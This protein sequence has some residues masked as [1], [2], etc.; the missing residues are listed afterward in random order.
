M[1]KIFLLIAILI[2]MF[3]SFSFFKKNKGKKPTSKGVFVNM[4]KV[5]IAMIIAFKDF[6]DEEC[7]V[8]KRIF[9]KARVEVKVVS[10]Q[11][12][13]ARGAHGGEIQ[14]DIQL[15][16][17]KVADFDGILFVGGPGA[18][19]HLDNED[20]YKIAKNS[21]AQNKLLAAICI[22]PVILAKAKV[23]EGK[24]AT[25]WTSAS[26]KS[27]AGILEEHGAIYQDDPVVQDSNIITGNGPMAAKDFAKKIIETLGASART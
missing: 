1:N 17:L 9:D 23:L 14:V 18:L 26:D 11:L 2:L 13:M 21:I 25:V 3:I 15:S 27:A 24:K 10:D 4:P 5:K 8:P 7:F 22:S 12:G 19:V 16:D 6:R 20:G